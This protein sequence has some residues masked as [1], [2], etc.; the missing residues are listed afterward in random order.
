[1]GGMSVL[2]DNDKYYML[3][4]TLFGDF[5]FQRLKLHPIRSGTVVT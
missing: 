1:L 2:D 3:T 5:R 4:R